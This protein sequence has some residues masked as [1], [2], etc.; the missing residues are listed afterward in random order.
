MRGKI[1][2]LREDKIVTTSDIICLSE[3]WLLS[4]ENIDTIQ[5]D[6]YV[7]RANGVG[8]GKGIATY[9]KQNKFNHCHD[10]KE[11]Y[12]IRKIYFETKILKI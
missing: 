12:F 1:E 5:I 11:K 3:T 6:G 4:D 9:F 10:I 8:H 2:H 7:L